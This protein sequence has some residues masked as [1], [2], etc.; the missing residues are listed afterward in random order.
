MI[1]LIVSRDS[2]VPTV[3]GQ[4][5]LD[6]ADRHPA[7]IETD[8]HLVQAAETTRSLGHQPRRERPVPVPRHIQRDRTDLRGQRLRRRCRCASSRTTTPP[9]RPSHNPGDQLSS[10]LKPALERRLDQPRHQPAIASQL[11]LTSVD[12]G[13]QRIQRARS[14]QLLDRINRHRRHVLISHRHHH[15]PFRPTSPLH[16]RSDTPHARTLGRGRSRPSTGEAPQARR[17]GSCSRVR[18]CPATLRAAMTC[19]LG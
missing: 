5:M 17:C 11:H 19:R 16:R 9:H 18:R 15:L 3:D 4:V 14:R 10:T 6:I 7:G 1:L 8:D 2:S 13:E 12:L